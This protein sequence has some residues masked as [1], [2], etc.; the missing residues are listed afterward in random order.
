[1]VKTALEGWKATAIAAVAA[2]ALCWPAQQAHALSLGRIKVLS[3][4]GEPLLAEVDVSTISAEESATLQASIAPP[5]AFRAAGLEYN[6]ALQDL[7][8]TLQQRPD[9]RA[10]LRLSSERRA[11]TPFVDVILQV[12]WAS[13][14]AVRDYTILLDPPAQRQ[15]APGSVTAPQ[16][17]L[18]APAPVA[19]PAAAKAAQPV[20]PTP[21]PAPATASAPA[22]PPAP[23]APATPPR[24]AAS[25][26]TVTVKPGDT[27]SRIAAAAKAPRISLDQMLVAMLRSN[28]EAFIQ[29]NVNRLKAGAVLDLPTPEQ[30]AGV[31]APEA[32][33]MIT[34]QSRDFNAFR[35]R[36]AS[37]APP[38]QTDA[39]DRSA[40]GRVQAQVDEN[41][42]GAATSDKL[43]LS[44]GGEQARANE[45]RIAREKATAQ[46][47]ERVAELSRN[48]SDLNRLGVA[49]PGSAPAAGTASSAAATG[50]ADQPPVVNAPT[51][52][53]SAPEVPAS[54][55]PTPVPPPQPLPATERAGWLNSLTANPLIPAAAAALIA[56]LAAL[57]LFRVRQRRRA[58]AE[59]AAHADGAH[60]DSFFGASGGQQVDTAEAQASVPPG[61]AYSPSQLD[62][63]G[64]VDPIAEADVY[65]AYGRDLQAEEIL[66]EALRADPERVAI[67]A[68]LAEIYAKRRDSAAFL[69]VATQADDLT[70]GVGP[71]W[72]QIAALGQEL[73]PGDL[74]WSEAP[75]PASA[76]DA[77]VTGAAIAAAS[78][79][80][81]SAAAPQATA[82]PFPN[83]DFDLDL[84]PDAEPQPAPGKPATASSASGVDTA[85]KEPPL[86]DALDF[87]LDVDVEPYPSS[88]QGLQE[89]KPA[90][91]DAGEPGFDL[92]SLNLDL[93]DDL[94]TDTAA[95]ATPSL[96]DPLATKLALAEEFHAIGDADGARA[97]A[98]EV[99]AEAS[100]PL[101]SQAQR[102][103]DT[104]G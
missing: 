48:I 57:A 83:L 68:K 67:H 80:A 85:P 32:S 59:N 97:L 2:A 14:R 30:A 6:P 81:D 43:T 84:A 53:A 39:A 61:A 52:P 72:A 34:A 15:A 64:D 19:P 27:A 23:A 9:G 102:F 44:K 45:D 91:A 66:K 98:Q 79:Q 55:P 62:T 54:A 93:G 36:L 29:G 41:R 25:N 60:P 24:A 86:A 58:A 50:A 42:P 7:R 38:V 11:T 49:V 99:L 73:I 74:L 101:K 56:L 26:S 47:D 70:G 103:L 90:T 65:L 12:S 20:A 82:A 63:G 28:P 16:V 17:P 4:L 77:A 94:G 3:A 76:A 31:P 95:P 46:A 89:R 33:R 40:S 92:G 10:V 5:A 87:D 78:T 96:D 71:E 75:T 100:G 1:M 22:R 37:K 51:A 35:G 88:R 13:G 21:S 8:I 104:L 69:A 18:P